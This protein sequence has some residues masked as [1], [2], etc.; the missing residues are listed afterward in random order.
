[1]IIS[2]FLFSCSHWHCYFF[3]QIFSKSPIQKSQAHI[4]SQKIISSVKLECCWFPEHSATIC[5]IPV[6]SQSPVKPLLFFQLLNFVCCFLDNIQLILLLC[7]LLLNLLF[8]LSVV[9]FLIYASLIWF[10]FP[11][12]WN[13]FRVSCTLHFQIYLISLSREA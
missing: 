9:V 2:I 13:T 4:W 10:F 7:D 8:Q 1:M 6:L 12:C 3:Y 11:V 5:W